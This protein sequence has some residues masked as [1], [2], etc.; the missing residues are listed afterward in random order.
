MTE[1]TLRKKVEEMLTRLPE[2]QMTSPQ[3]RML[4][5][6]LDGL[7]ESI[8][9]DGRAS[10]AVTVIQALR[11][12]GKTTVLSRFLIA[13]MLC[14]PLEVVLFSEEIHFSSRKIMFKYEDI[15]HGLKLDGYSYRVC[16]KSGEIDY[17]LIRNGDVES[18]LY[19]RATNYASNIP[20]C[21]LF[22]MEDCN[23]RAPD[24][25]S[26]QE[27]EEMQKKTVDRFYNDTSGPA[28]PLGIP[29]VALK[30]GGMSFVDLY[31]KA[32]IP[33][34]NMKS[35]DILVVGSYNECDEPFAS[36]SKIEGAKVFKKE[37]TAPY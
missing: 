12:L 1:Q 24:F 4:T 28:I 35:T 9:K 6:M 5:I 7:D 10:K 32:I 16:K 33:L 8:L 25:N 21:D 23:F 29:A 2:I 22:V 18:F 34:Q 26:Y 17:L 13:L 20:V 19:N 11:R 14:I 15:L 37:E 27:Y 3:K 31:Q 36:F 30:F